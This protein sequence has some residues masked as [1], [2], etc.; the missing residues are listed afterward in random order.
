M[1]FFWNISERLLFMSYLFSHPGQNVIGNAYNRRFESDLVNSVS[2]Y[3]TELWIIDYRGY[4]YTADIDKT[5]A[6][7]NVPLLC[8]S[9]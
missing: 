8:L 3:L 5:A 2:G 6:V 4:P 9:H 1:F 7:T